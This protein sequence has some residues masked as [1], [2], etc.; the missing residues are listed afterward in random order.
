MAYFKSFVSASALPLLHSSI[1]QGR[2]LDNYVWI[3]VER[4]LLKREA[5]AQGQ[6][7]AFEPIRPFTCGRSFNFKYMPTSGYRAL[8]LVPRPGDGMP[9]PGGGPRLPGYQTTCYNALASLGCHV[10]L[11]CAQ[12]ACTTCASVRFGCC[13]GP[14]VPPPHPQG[15]SS[16]ARFLNMTG[17]QQPVRLSEWREPASVFTTARIHRC[18][19]RVHH[20]SY[21]P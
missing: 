10:L 1:A 18:E 5:R 21:A 20:H 13:Q 14:P 16:P 8:N 17:T 11:C 15:P 19:S 6:G 4:G 12:A 7:G 2:L 3:S 9:R